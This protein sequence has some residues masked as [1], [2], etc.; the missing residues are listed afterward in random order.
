MVKHLKNSSLSS[1]FELHVYPCKDYTSTSCFEPSIYFKNV[2]FSFFFVHKSRIFGLGLKLFFFAP[3][4]ATFR[5]S[6][7]ATLFGCSTFIEHT[8]SHLLTNS[9]YFVRTLWCVN[10][11]I[12]SPPR[13]MR[14]SFFPLRGTCI[15]T[16]QL[17]AWL[18]DSLFVSHL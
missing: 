15:Q 4:T 14:I 18:T 8:F 11:S 1:H 7:L 3:V 17:T 5:S 10:V 6:F 9:S 13:H 12:L 16:S 2:L